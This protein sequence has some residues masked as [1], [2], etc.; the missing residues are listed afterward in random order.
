MLD[1][2]FIKFIKAENRKTENRGEG[3][4]LFVAGL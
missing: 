3:I 2:T 1:L 4:E